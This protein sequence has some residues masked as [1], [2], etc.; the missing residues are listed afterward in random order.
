MNGICSY[1]SV[2]Y[3]GVKVFINRNYYYAFLFKQI[4]KFL[5]EEG[6]NH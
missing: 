2:I 4:S 5:L 3:D 6:K 1:Y